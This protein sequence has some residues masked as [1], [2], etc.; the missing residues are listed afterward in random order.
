MSAFAPAVQA[1]ELAVP[2]VCLWAGLLLRSFRHNLL[3]ITYLALQNIC[4]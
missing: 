2:M 1:A 4:S 3:A